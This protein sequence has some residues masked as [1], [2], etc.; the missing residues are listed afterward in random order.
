[1]W[2]TILDHI[3]AVIPSQDS[4]P[5]QRYFL[6]RKESVQTRSVHSVTP[7]CKEMQTC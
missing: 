1:M 5:V 2:K 7:T 4:S 3:N 6:P